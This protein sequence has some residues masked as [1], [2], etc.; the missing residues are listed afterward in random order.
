MTEEGG[1]KVNRVL[2]LPLY[3]NGIS[4]HNKI[5]YFI[6]WIYRSKFSVINFFITLISCLLYLK[7]WH[8]YEWSQVDRETFDSDVLNVI[9]LWSKIY[10]KYINSCD[11]YILNLD[12]DYLTFLYYISPCLCTINNVFVTD[13]K[14]KRRTFHQ[15]HYILV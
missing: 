8:S 1:W 3:E 7:S 13:D 12:I 2:I 15:V 10:K 6:K 4:T 9:N 5:L 14:N 11:K